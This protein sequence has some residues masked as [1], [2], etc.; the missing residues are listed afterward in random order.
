MANMPPTASELAVLNLL[1]D[2]GSLTVR[3]VY[4]ELAKDK[5]IVY[6]TVLKT[7]QV[8]YERGFVSRERLGRGHIYSASIERESTQ[9]KL[10][11]G[12]LGKTFGGS[13][14]RLVMR[15]LGNYRTSKDELQELKALIERLENEEQ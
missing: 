15:A 6:T 14:Q 8:M 4:D 7:M 13:A 9:D 2:R 5:D 11:D 1:W 3:A 12:F 10:L